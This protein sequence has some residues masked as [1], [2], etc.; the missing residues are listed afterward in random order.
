MPLLVRERLH[1]DQWCKAQPARLT[2]ASFSSCS[3]LNCRTTETHKK[4]SLRLPTKLH[5]AGTTVIFH[6]YLYYPSN[7]IPKP[8]LN[9]VTTRG[10]SKPSADPI[11]R[12]K[13]RKF[14]KTDNTATSPMILD[15]SAQGSTAAIANDSTAQSSR[16]LQGLPEPHS[17]GHEHANASD[18]NNSNEIL[19]ADVDADGKTINAETHGVEDSA[20]N[21]SGQDA[22][23]RWSAINVAK[24]IPLGST[25]PS[26][27]PGVSADVSCSSKKQGLTPSDGPHL[28]KAQRPAKLWKTDSTK[29]GSS[30][31]HAPKAG[32]I[33]Y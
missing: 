30:V 17:D 27:R 6:S 14:R 7:K 24:I 11:Q 16:E 5:A 22:T 3:Q 2:M 31:M 21:V 19:D 18:P 9:M 10:G 25:E 28:S 1:Q 4:A 12:T 8:E 32:E 33:Q 23:N 15:P 26:L 13:P 20:T 29:D